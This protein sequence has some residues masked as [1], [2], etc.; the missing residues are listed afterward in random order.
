MPNNNIRINTSIP[1]LRDKIQMRI[2][3]PTD[4]I[5]WYI[6]FNIPL[7]E[8]TVSG[9]TM[10]VTDTEGYIMRT[11]I[12]FERKNNMIVISPLDTYEQNRFYLLNISKRVKSARGN[13]LRSTIHILFKL[14][15]NAISEFKVLK[16]DVKIPPP[17]V[18]PKDYDERQKNRRPSHF[19]REYIEKTT[20]DRM[21]TVGFTFN[22][23]VAILGFVIVAVGG[24]LANW[25]VMLAGAAVCVG[26][27]THI[28]V[29]MRR[30]TLRSILMFNRGVRHFNRER[31]R[32]AEKC[33]KRALT[34]NP[35]NDKA[36]Y[37]LYK[38]GL[39]H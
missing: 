34:F 9:K 22:P 24:F 26:G 20:L 7:D 35:D 37:G 38:V 12:Y 18:R 29:Q 39:Y 30:D 2:D 13:P 14:Y 16:S 1:G 23:L 11:D 31:Y 5:H 4:V 28:V 25:I 33:F 17:L 10:N 3:E 32:E 21:A 27:F 6:R 8:E 36:E 19:D 15:G